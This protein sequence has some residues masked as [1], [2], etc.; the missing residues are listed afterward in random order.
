[1]SNLNPQR[2][3]QVRVKCP[4]CGYELY[5]VGLKVVEKVE[6]DDVRFVFVDVDLSGLY[7]FNPAV[8]ACVAS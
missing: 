1:M 6:R 7:G 3:K 5:T 8:T 4:K 2:E